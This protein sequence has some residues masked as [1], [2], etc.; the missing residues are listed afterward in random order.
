MII[1]SGSFKYFNSNGTQVTYGDSTH[2]YFH[3]VTG[4]NKIK[5]YVSSIK[6][7]PNPTSDNLVTIKTDVSLNTG[8]LL[9]IYNTLGELIKSERLVQNQQQLYVGDL[10]SGLY[11][12]SVKS[13]D[14]NYSQKLII[15][16]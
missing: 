6:L 4:S 15:Q 5:E 10:S 14:Q 13:N 7:F 16:H 9:E 2:Y 1:T 3:L 11:M 12:V 8:A